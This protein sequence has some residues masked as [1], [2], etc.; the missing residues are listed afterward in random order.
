MQLLSNSIWYVIRWNV[1]SVWQ[2]WCTV[3]K[4]PFPFRALIAFCNLWWTPSLKSWPFNL[5][6]LSIYTFPWTAQYFKAVVHETLKQQGKIPL[7][8]LNKSSFSPCL[9]NAIRGRDVV[10]MQT[11]CKYTTSTFFLSVILVYLHVLTKLKFV[12]SW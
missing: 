11:S 6:L 4:H 10:A 9:F 3:C 1:S 7:G 8:P 5:Q 12:E 2:R